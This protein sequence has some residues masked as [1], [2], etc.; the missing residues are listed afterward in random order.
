[1]VS[2]RGAERRP[3]PPKPGSA[4]QT[5]SASLSWSAS[6]PFYGGAIGGGCFLARRRSR[7]T[8]VGG[9]LAGHRRPGTSR[10]RD[11]RENAGEHILRR[12]EL[13]R[14]HDFLQRERLR[15]FHVPADLKVEIVDINHVSVY[16][17]NANARRN[18]SFGVNTELSKASNGVS[19]SGG[20]VRRKSSP[21]ISG[22]CKRGR[23]IDVLGLGPETRWPRDGAESRG[24]GASRRS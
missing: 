13:V 22:H 8:G 3:S 11:R 1:M 16:L 9:I 14:L 21:P 6:R 23:G 20:R 10:N 18:T 12:R 17:P 5:P 24:Q 15:V 2:R 4:R 7:K 19:R